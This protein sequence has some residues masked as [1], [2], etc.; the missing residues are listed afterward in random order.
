MKTDFRSPA[1]GHIA[2]FLEIL[3]LWAISVY[4]VKDLYLSNVPLE[5]H[6]VEQWVTVIQKSE[7][8]LL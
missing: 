2:R 1:L 8:L 6:N 3:K 5:R 7:S 4:S